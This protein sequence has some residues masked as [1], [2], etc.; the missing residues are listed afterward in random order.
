MNYSYYSLHLP[1][2]LYVTPNL[3]CE[4]GHPLLI[5]STLYI[6][7]L[8]SDQITVFA[9]HSLIIFLWCQVLFPKFLGNKDP[10][11]FVHLFHNFFRF[12][13]EIF[14][15]LELGLWKFLRKGNESLCVYGI[16]NLFE[17]FHTSLDGFIVFFKKIRFVVIVVAITS[18][19]LYLLWGVCFEVLSVRVRV[20]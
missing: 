4:L 3:F 10:H 2:I 11:D 20:S 19:H 14:V 9:Y 16:F 15:D 17:G 18:S 8:T 12:L 1:N 5:T 7:T 6:V 13:L